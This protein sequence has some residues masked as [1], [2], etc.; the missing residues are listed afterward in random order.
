[1]WHGP[2]VCRTR[3]PCR[4]HQLLQHIL[5]AV[6]LLRAWVMLLLLLFGCDPPIAAVLP[7]SSLG[8]RSLQGNG[9]AGHRHPLQTLHVSCDCALGHL[10]LRLLLA[11]G[12]K[13]AHS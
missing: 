12:C 3:P 5:T 6:L 1:M 13:A 9:M 10:R 11:V 2:T 7:P 8:G 4:H